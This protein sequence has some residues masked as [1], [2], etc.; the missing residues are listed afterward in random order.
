MGGDGAA[1]VTGVAATGVAGIGVVI[2]IIADTTA[3]AA[4]METVDTVPGTATV[5]ADTVTMDTVAGTDI[6]ADTVTRATVAETAIVAVMEAPAYT[7]AA[8]VVEPP[9]RVEPGPATDSV[10]VRHAPS[11]EAATAALVAAAIAE[12]ARVADLGAVVAPV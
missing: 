10:T 8:L 11:R 1:P 2:G 6:A 7:R 5:V 3:T 9:M 4:D 12:Y